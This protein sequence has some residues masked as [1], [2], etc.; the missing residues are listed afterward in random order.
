MLKLNKS[1]R[2]SHLLNSSF[3]GSSTS[4]SNSTQDD[5]W[6]SNSREVV[7]K[8]P[9]VNGHF[10]KSYQ[11]VLINR[12]CNSLHLGSDWFALQGNST[13]V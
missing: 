4:S 8:L 3:G 7:A 11:L 9:V 13:Q 5:E 12:C 6:L 2:V 10:Q 1:A